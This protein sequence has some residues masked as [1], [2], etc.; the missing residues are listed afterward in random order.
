MD[1]ADYAGL[2]Y[3]V[4]ILVLPCCHDLEDRAMFA[5][6]LAQE[7]RAQFADLVV[8]RT[9]IPPIVRQPFTLHEVGIVDLAFD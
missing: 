8:R 4:L 1:Q 7:E 9:E 5:E 2:A 6:G 3:E